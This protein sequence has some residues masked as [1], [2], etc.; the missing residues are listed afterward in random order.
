MNGPSDADDPASRIVECRRESG[1]V[2]YYTYDDADRLTSETWRDSGG[3]T[4]YAFEWD[5]DRVGNRTRQKRGSVET[6][7]TYDGEEAVISEK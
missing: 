5:Y 2:V 4:I 3:G 6:Y 1:T 7:Y